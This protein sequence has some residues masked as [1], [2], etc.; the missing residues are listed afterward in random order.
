M[1]ELMEDLERK[2]EAEFA[3]E[4]QR[5]RAPADLWSR[6]EA[7]LPE[8]AEAHRVLPRRWPAFAATAA[9]AV[10]L[11]IAV[12]FVTGRLGGNS[13]GA[14]EVLAGALDTLENPESAG[15]RSFRG[16]LEEEFAVAE[17][18]ELEDESEED[19]GLSDDPSIVEANIPEAI[20]MDELPPPG[21]VRMWF[22]VPDRYRVE[23]EMLGESL[24]GV[25][26]GETIL[27]YNP[28]DKTYATAPADSPDAADFPITFSPGEIPGTIQEVLALV[29]A[30][31][32]RR[33]T[34]VG[35]DSM[36]GHP[37]YVIEANSPLEPNTKSNGDDEMS[38]GPIRFWIDK[39]YLFPLAWTASFAPGLTWG[40]R[41]SEVE[42]N[43]G[44]DDEIFSVTPPEGSRRVD[45]K[46][47]ADSVQAGFSGGGSIEGDL[48]QE[49][50]LPAGFLAPTYLPTG[51]QTR[52][53]GQEEDADGIYQVEFLIRQ[54]AGDGYISAQERRG[55]GAIPD[56]LK[57]G[58]LVVAHD[59]QA[60][61]REEDDLLHL[62]W[63]ENDL[64]IYV[65]A[66]GLT[67]DELLRVADSMQVSADDCGA[68]HSPGCDRAMPAAIE[69]RVP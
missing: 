6:I 12:W 50:S 29:E 69:T 1:S 18:L 7:R 58:D 54:D 10:A 14:D 24:V 45:A 63:Q 19:E 43:G 32:D 11:A 51:Y 33:A 41:F 27:Q 39:Q 23:W 44:I 28:D 59:V 3:A 60:W 25:T 16:V 64:V 38:G 65:I 9:V 57:K 30:D 26:D 22:E 13:P 67:A 53:I 46:E 56:A 48:G 52:A 17:G 55:R 2:L 4:R 61:L 68:L 8:R 15:L 62:A 66:R 42:F 36:L 34:L 21:V 37:V 20:R 5:L 49:V 31:T 35:E 47:L 40:M